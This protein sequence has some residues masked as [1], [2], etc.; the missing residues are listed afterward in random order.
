MNNSLIQDFDKL[1]FEGWLDFVFDHKWSSSKDEDYIELSDLGGDT[2]IFVRNCVKLFENPVFLLDKYNSEQLEGGFYYFILS[3]KVS[4]N[5]WIWDKN[6]PAELRRQFIFSSVNVF[7]RVFTKNPLE[8]SCFMWW[9]CLRDFDKNKDKQVE[10]WM[11]AAL[12]QILEI[13]NPDCQ[14]SALHGL[15]HI[16]HKGKKILIE[17]FLRQNPKFGDKEYALAAIAGKI[18]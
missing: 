17:K 8:H 5:W 2:E 12:S 11:F 3:P 18:L 4:L 9:D 15:G 7:K 1:S 13:N 10:N 16:E 14:L 6:S